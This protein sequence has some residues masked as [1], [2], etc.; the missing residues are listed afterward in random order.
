MKIPTTSLFAITLLS[1][2]THLHAASASY[3]LINNQTGNEFKDQFGVALDS[4]TPNTENGNGT[5][6]QLGYF[7]I[8]TSAFTGDWMPIAGLDSA[9]ASLTLNIGDF[10]AQTGSTP[11]PDGLYSTT[12]TFDSET[13]KDV[14]L[15]SADTQLAIRFYNGNDPSSNHYNTVTRSGWTFT[16]LSDQGSTT[17][18]DISGASQGTLMWQDGGANAFKTTIVA[19]PEPASFTLL[20]LGA[21]GLV[22]RRR[23]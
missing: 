16:P 17:A 14:G 21:L 9:N 8:S 11:I 6:F 2:Y 10:D 3:W 22:F 15:P 12:V 19:V 4:G 18:L 7:S 5:V 20:G 1:T 23:R 13:G